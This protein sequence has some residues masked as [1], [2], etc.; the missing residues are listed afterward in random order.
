[1]RYRNDFQQFC[2]L[3]QYHGNTIRLYEIAAQI[4]NENVKNMINKYEKLGLI[5]F[6][7]QMIDSMKSSVK[8]KAFRVQLSDMGMQLYNY[9]KGKITIEY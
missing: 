8:V 9:L 4:G 3:G 2:W 1:M 5:S 7:E 6:T